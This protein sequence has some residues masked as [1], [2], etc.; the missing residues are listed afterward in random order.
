[1]GNRAVA[2]SNYVTAVSTS[3]EERPEASSTE[4][5]APDHGESL[6]EIGELVA[7]AFRVRELLGSGG[8]GQVYEAHDESLN[9]TVALKV[10]WPHVDGDDLLAEARA[11]AALRHPGVVAVHAIARHRDR[12]CL[13]MERIYGRTLSEHLDRLAR[14]G[15][16]FTVDETVATLS[17]LCTVVAAVHRAGLMHGDLKPANVVLAANRRVVLLDFGVFQPERALAAQPQLFATPCY[18][19]PEL[20]VD[21]V[22]PGH[23]YLVDVYAAGVVAYEMLLGQPPYFGD[24]SMQTLMRHVSEPVPAVADRRPDVPAWLDRLV[25]SMMA[26]DPLERPESMDAVVAQ[27]RARRPTRRP[28]AAAARPSVLLV[29]DDD[30]FRAFAEACVRRA[31]PDAEVRLAVDGGDALEQFRQHPPSVVVTDLQMPTLNG[32][33]LCMYLRGTRLADPVPIVAM[34]AHADRSDRELLH[35]LGVAHVLSKRASG[36]ESFARSL[37][38]ALHRSLGGTY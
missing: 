8:M 28:P 27:L 10:A 26:K 4:A 23:G 7:D 13:V 12:P 19:A 35:H 16:R 31:L 17:E 9:R 30:D 11:L 34:S 37:E 38:T 18:A 25:A 36:P 3:L 33:E 21:E 24:T 5:S 2:A 15:A 22:Q 20:V 29:D 32:I 1:M 14:S 6:L